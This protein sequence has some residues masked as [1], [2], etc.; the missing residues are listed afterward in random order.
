MS[1]LRSLTQATL[2]AD[3][4]SNK[5]G[6]SEL[7][8]LDETKF[9]AAIAEASVADLE[10]VKEVFAKSASISPEQREMLR[11][12]VNQRVATLAQS[13]E[14]RGAVAA[15]LQK[16]LLDLKAETVGL[17]S[18]ILGSE[19]PDLNALQARASAWLAKAEAN[20]A[21]LEA[22]GKT[23]IT[24]ADFKAALKGLIGINSGADEVVQVH[25]T[26]YCDDLGRREPGK[27]L[28]IDAFDAAGFHVLRGDIYTEDAGALYIAGLRATH[29]RNVDDLGLREGEAKIPGRGNTRLIAQ[30]FESAIEA[31]LEQGFTKLQCMPGGPSVAK[32]YYKMGFRY[33]ETKDPDAYIKFE[34]MT[35]DLTDKERIDQIVFVFAA[36]RAGITDVPKNIGERIAAAGEW[37][38]PPALGK[39]T[40][41]CFLREDGTETVSL[42]KD[43]A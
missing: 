32:L 14:A 35:L 4:A 26:D 31:A 43:G 40:K 12:A 6:F 21:K 39:D 28:S 19:L 33:E 29:G 37:Q 15:Q 38:S 17:F 11:N 22:G 23:P 30:A 13:G 9:K 3:T 25:A 18:G 2:L 7:V 1:T 5:Y 24:P 16:Q 20:K 36:S 34:T 41:W 10:S 27:F 8:P 42:I